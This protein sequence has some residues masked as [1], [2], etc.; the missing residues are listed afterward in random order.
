MYHSATRKLIPS[1]ILG[2]FA[3]SAGASGFQSLEQSSSGIGSAFAGSAAVA[4][5]AST[6]FYNPAGM[7]ESI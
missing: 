2:T 1:L 6:I 7:T 5:N 3:A 4:E